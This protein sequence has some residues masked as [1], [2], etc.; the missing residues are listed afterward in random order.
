MMKKVVLSLLLVG[1][2][3]AGASAS[4]ILDLRVV[5]VTD[6]NPN[7][8][9][10]SYIDAVATLYPSDTA[11]IELWVTISGGSFGASAIDYNGTGLGTAWSI[12]SYAPI[13]PGGPY[14]SGDL[15]DWNG[16]PLGLPYQSLDASELGAYA[17]TG[18]FLLHRWVVHCEAAGLDG[19]LYIPPPPGNL[20]TNVS[21]FATGA[22]W[23]FPNGGLTFSATGGSVA[24]HNIPEP[25]SLALLGLG[26]LAL[27]R[28]R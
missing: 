21:D 17:P 7:P 12:V 14:L 10:P 20:T 18:L 27:L 4:A 22:V 16:G 2:M 3:T 5:G 13:T 24:I 9:H 19:T 15:V 23:T 25:A 6:G 11:T 28:R 26:G 1:A 8:E